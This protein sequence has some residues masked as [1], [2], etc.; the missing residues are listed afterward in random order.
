MPPADHSFDLIVC[1]GGPAGVAAALAAARRGART[2]LLERYGFCGGMATAALVNPWAGHEFAEPGTRR[3]GSLI[4]GL[5]KEICQ[6]L[7]DRG[8]YGSVLSASAFD[9]ELLKHIYDGLLVGAGVT[10]RY[11]SY[12]RSVRK[13]GGRVTTIEVLSKGGCENFTARTVIDGSGDGDVAALAGL[14]FSV[15]RPSDGLTQA[16]TVSFRMANVDKREMI[17]IGVLRDARALVEPYFQRALASGELHYPFRNFIHFYDYPRP[18]VLHFN[19]T[20]INQVSGLSAADL[21]AAEIEGRRQAYLIGE[22]LVKAVPCFRHA[23]VEKVAC[24]VGVRET[25]HIHGL[26]TLQQEDIV[27]A[28]KFADGIVR[29]CYF[30]DIHNPVGNQDVHQKPGARGAPRAD[31]SPP[32]GDWYEVPFRCLVTADCPNLLVA[33]RALSATHEASAA[34]R[35]MATM[36]GIGEA[37]GIAA[38]EAVRRGVDVVSIPGGWVR[39]EIPYLAQGVDYGSPWHGPGNAAGQAVDTRDGRRGESASIRIS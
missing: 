17:A 27:G 24:Q 9:E 13:E 6:E 22:W 39:G 38:A 30:I 8:G 12:L 5:F 31:F 3:K 1:G 29:S 37:A 34:V 36:H 33:C 32:P 11:H 35:V 26:Y 21:T 18:G 28:R 23:Y 19:M 15:G 20:R 10:V 2:L 16:M 25:R 4:G 7:R 14:P